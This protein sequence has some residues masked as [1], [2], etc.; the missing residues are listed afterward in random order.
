MRMSK[1]FSQT[2]R[3]A[4]S[5]AEVTSH[6]LLVRAGFIVQLGAGIF[7]YLPLARR[8]MNKIENIIRE[9]MNAIGGQEITM[10]VIHPA[11][12]WKETRRWQQIGDEMGRFKDRAGRDMALAMT[13]EEVVGDL[14]RKEVRSY[15]QLPLLIYHIQTKWRDDPRPRAGL[16]RVREF[17]MKDSYSLDADWEGLDRQYRAHY[18]AYFNIFHRCG[19]PA[20]AVK[21]DVGMMGGQLAHEFMYLTPIGEDTLLLCDGP[22]GCGYTANRQVARF[23]KETPPAEAMQ[24]IEKVATPD[25]T[26]IAGLADFLGVPK[27][28]TAKAVFLVGTFLRDGQDVD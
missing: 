23:R 3:E 10:P 6:Q 18:Q 5:D 13:H 11:D 8:A 7:S 2:L 4:P 15:R 9:E 26:T 19:L 25:Q 22:Q 1:L 20:V 21:S 24:P 12:L 16:I 27:S 14:A 17:T 28:R